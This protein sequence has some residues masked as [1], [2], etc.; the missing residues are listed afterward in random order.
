[1]FAYAAPIPP[2]LGWAAAVHLPPSLPPSSLSSTLSRFPLGML[3]ARQPRKLTHSRRSNQSAKLELPA[4]SFAGRVRRLTES[5]VHPELRSLMQ[6]RPN[7]PTNE[8]RFPKEFERR[9][10]RLKLC[11]VIVPH[12]TDKLHM[13][14]RCRD[15]PLSKNM[16]L[17][18]RLLRSY[19]SGSIYFLYTKASSRRHSNG[20]NHVSHWLTIVEPVPTCQ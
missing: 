12:V 20:T 4:H 9:T 13:L 8:F 5:V 17:T 3:L 14:G 18:H 11:P 16:S 1:M 2:F 15:D 6:K 10:V 19:C 7:E